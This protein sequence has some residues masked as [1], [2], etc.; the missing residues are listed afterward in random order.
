MTR[1]CV[2][3]T[4]VTVS[5]T[6]ALVAAGN[7]WHRDGI[8]VSASEAAGIRGGQCGKFQMFASG[9]CGDGASDTCTS[10]TS[11]CDGLC[12]LACSPTSTYGG[13]GTFTGSLV[14]RACDASTQ[15]TCA[16]SQCVGSGG[17]P[18]DCC[19]CANAAGVQC[20]PSGF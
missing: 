10:S 2:A 19:V 6:T 9:A 12:P 4:F 3:M 18:Q 17:L 20:G 1:L 5:I 11:D 8:V 7:L 15:A 14:S 16:Q 13:S